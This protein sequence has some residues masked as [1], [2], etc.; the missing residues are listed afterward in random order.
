M[1]KKNIFITGAS[2]QDANILYKKFKYKK[3]YRIFLLSNKKKTN[4]YKNYIIANYNKIDVLNELFAA[5][6]PD[7]IIHLGSKNPFYGQKGYRL[8]YKNNLENS[9]NLLNTSIK[10]NSKIRFIFANSS[11]IFKKRKGLVNEKSKIF[12]SSHYTKFRIEFDKYAK[13]L[14]RKKQFKY[15]NVIL[16][17]H[18]SIY[19]RK[20]F[21]IPRIVK[22]LKNN[23]I[24]FIKYIMRQNISADFSHAEDV[25]EGLYRLVFT[26]SDCENIILS[27]NKKTYINDIIHYLIIKKKLNYFFDNKFIKGPGCIIGDHNLAKK[28]L[29]WRPKKN[30][31]QASLEIYNKT[32]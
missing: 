22:A 31:Y 29:R 30:I 20:N 32:K 11:Q 3:R 5:H 27:S 2:G 26:R 21:L 8:F 17:N 6:T 14:K 12:I 25:C 18:D 10:Y 4:S 9:K 1:K 13:I 23:N 19:R 28:I 16:F 24:N 7:V 15:F